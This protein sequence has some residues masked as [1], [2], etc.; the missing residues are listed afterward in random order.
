MKRLGRR[1][2]GLLICA[3]IL[4]SLCAPALAAETD[5]DLALA[6]GSAAA[7]EEAEQPGDALDPLSAG[8]LGELY[9]PEPVT[10]RYGTF[11][12]DGYPAV[13]EW[14]E[15]NG[16]A[17]YCYYDLHLTAE[18]APGFVP[19]SG[20]LVY[21]RTSS[22]T[23]IVN[24]GN[25]LYP[26]DRAGA[27]TSAESVDIRLQI[28]SGGSCT[29]KVALEYDGSELPLFE[30]PITVVAAQ[31][32]NLS[33]SMEGRKTSFISGEPVAV[34][35][36]YKEDTYPQPTGFTWQG[37]KQEAGGAWTDVGPAVTL[38]RGVKFTW[39]CPDVAETSLC[40]VLCTPAGGPYP[41]A[42]RT[43]REV[44]F[45]VHPR[46]APPVVGE[47]GMCSPGPV[48]NSYGTFT[49]QDYRSDIELIEMNSQF[50]Y[51]SLS[52]QLTAQLPEG[53]GGAEYE[54]RLTSSDTSVVRFGGISNVSSCSYPC[55]AD[56]PVSVEINF[57]KPGT[58]FVCVALYRKY[59]SDP[60]AVLYELPFT[61]RGEFDLN[62]GC[63]A[64]PDVVH[65]GAPY[66]LFAE[67]GSDT[68]KFPFQYHWKVERREYSKTSWEVYDEWD[69]AGYEDESPAGGGVRRRFTWYKPYGATIPALTA[70]RFTCTPYGYEEGSGL[71]TRYAKTF[72]SAGG[73]STQTEGYWAASPSILTE[74]KA[75]LRGLTLVA[76]TAERPFS[77][78]RDSSEEVSFGFYLMGLGRES[79]GY[80]YGYRVR[81]VSSDPSILGFVD[82][83]GGTQRPQAE[84]SWDDVS[85]DGDSLYSCYLRFQNTGKAVI[86]ILL[87]ETRGAGGSIVL[88]KEYYTI[89]GSAS[90]LTLTNSAAEAAQLGGKTVT[91]KASTSGARASQYL[92]KIEKRAGGS[93]VYG[94]FAGDF[95]TS[96]DGSVLNWVT[97][98]LSGIDTVS[99]RITCTPVI[100]GEKR[101]DCEKSEYV[102]VVPTAAIP[103]E[104]PD[105]NNFL[106]LSAPSGT[107]SLSQYT[108][109]KAKVTAP[110]YSLRD[111]QVRWTVEDPHVALLQNRAAV[112]GQKEG[113]VLTPL[114]GIQDPAVF[115]YPQRAGTTTVTAQL[116]QKF[117][118][119]GDYTDVGNPV[120]FQLT[121]TGGTPASYTVSFHANG[122]GGTM[123]RETGL[124]GSYLLP[125]NGFTPPQGKAFRGWALSAGGA[126]IRASMV[127]VNRDL[128][129]Y[130]VWVPE[131]TEAG[132]GIYMAVDTDRRTVEVLAYRDLFGPDSAPEYNAYSGALALYNGAGKLLDC[133][134]GSWPYSGECIR[135][136]ASWKDREVP[137]CK[138]FAWNGNGPTGSV[139]TLRLG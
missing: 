100:N 7:P 113:S 130:A 114:T 122:G 30:L 126:P 50:Q 36:K 119:E 86:T 17:I 120:A 91:L 62:I 132:P 6:E 43:P 95:T 111:P 34:T 13:I 107:I 134:V 131:R 87:E 42:F 77:I 39:T 40:R 3:S 82:S 10:N 102:L 137:V 123:A 38:E 52:Y 24:W 75:M 26:N 66:A 27:V 117:A 1:L 31:S 49:F 65:P 47:D 83:Q 4:W 136:T 71:L 25:A 139:R 67:C 37:Q 16:T 79:N 133:D 125:E 138:L 92:W 2:A 53:G 64:L 21:W 74:P 55:K 104:L 135:L 99:F 72:Y 110:T 112:S 106:R 15:K 32:A 45:R 11:R 12:L 124:R 105:S 61:V 73:P 103:E 89:N 20:K 22:D 96:G 98:C 97:P 60:A 101:F 90:T 108:D 56:Q 57:K 127:T 18:Y 19:E 46:P 5:V 54:Y 58:A 14:E 84:K 129:L 121:V 80:Y 51:E 94:E 116:V 93:G 69:D 68:G 28:W 9:T 41:G 44:Q 115:I 85:I 63:S 35:A 81:L 48:T 76:Y 128:T 23:D 8:V 59:A 70:Y 78:D 109:L 33:V 88:W 29:V 118:H